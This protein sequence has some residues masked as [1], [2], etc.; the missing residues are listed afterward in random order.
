L[1]FN[2]RL[3]F[4]TLLSL[5]RIERREVMKMLK[6][7]KVLTLALTASLAIVGAASAA[8]DYSS[9][10]IYNGKS[11]TGKMIS[12]YD[13]TSDF[14][15]WNDEDSSVLGVIAYAYK[16]IGPLL[17]DEIYAYEAMLPGDTFNR[18]LQ[19][20]TGQYYA[21]ISGFGTSTAGVSLSN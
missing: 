20:P 18:D 15:G 13:G 4:L 21:K 2:R 14:F 8:T 11:A 5:L 7:L 9:A 12:I 6:K 1:F 19:P 16:S 10:N 17:P 3:I